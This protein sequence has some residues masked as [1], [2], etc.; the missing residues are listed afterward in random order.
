[1]EPNQ[2]ATDQED[3]LPGVLVDCGEDAVSR[4]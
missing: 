3:E 2:D 4:D 1:M